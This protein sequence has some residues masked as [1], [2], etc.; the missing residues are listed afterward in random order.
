MW[1]SYSLE[2]I[3]DVLESKIQKNPETE[4]KLI[5]LG[6]E[7]T[8]LGE[9]IKK[10]SLKSSLTMPKQRNTATFFIFFKVSKWP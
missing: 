1:V 2:K 4:E 10:E 7:I 8:E 9:K 3:N 6:F 5:V